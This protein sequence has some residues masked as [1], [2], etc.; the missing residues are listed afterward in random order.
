M[1]KKQYSI[2]QN[3]RHF[4][5]PLLHQWIIPPQR[6]KHVQQKRFRGSV[7]KVLILF[8]KLQ[9]LI[10]RKVMLFLFIKAFRQFQ[11]SLIL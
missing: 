3:G 2:Q 1:M 10:N 4:S 7:F 8:Q 6:R 5:S 11:R 9:G